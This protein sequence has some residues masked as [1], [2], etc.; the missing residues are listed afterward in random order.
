MTCG[1]RAGRAACAS[2]A[3]PFDVRTSGKMKGVRKGAVAS[4]T[5]HAGEQPAQRTGRVLGRAPT[6]RTRGHSLSPPGP[7]AVSVTLCARCASQGHPGVRP[8]G[9]PGRSLTGPPRC[10]APPRPTPEA[11]PP[12]RQAVTG[13]GSEAGAHLSC[14][15]PVATGLTANGKARPF[16]ARRGFQGDGWRPHALSTLRL[17]LPPSLPPARRGPGIFRSFSL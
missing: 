9:T 2:P 15:S 6:P 5:G 8:A 17:C 4:A 16:R 11:A 10:T 14:S 13:R 7:T 1:R 3:R 12:L